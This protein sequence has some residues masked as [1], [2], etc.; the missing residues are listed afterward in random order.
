MIIFVRVGT[1]LLT[2][3]NSGEDK[4]WTQVHGPPFLDQNPYMDQVHGPLVMDWV[5]G[6][7]FLISPTPKK[8]IKEGEMNN[9]NKQHSTNYS[10][11]DRSL[12]M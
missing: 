12:F 1:G 8:T 11:R 10:F 4:T 2:G 7:F 6:N 5:Y 3:A 9:A